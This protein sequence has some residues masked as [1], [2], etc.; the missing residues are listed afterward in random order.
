MN[1]DEPDRKSNRESAVPSGPSNH[2]PA[3]SPRRERS[4][5]PYNPGLHQLVESK[6]AWAEPLDEEAEADGFLGWHQRGYLPHHDVPG[7]TQFLTFRLEDAMPASRRGEWALL[8]QIEDDRRRRTKLEEYLDRGFGKCWLRR[9][10]IAEVVESELRSADGQAYRLCAW[11]IMPNHVH[12]LVEIWETPLAVLSRNW[13]GR[14]AREANKRLNRRGAF[15]ERE[16]WDTRMR[17]EKQLRTAQHYVESNPVK[18][19]LVAEART[20]PWGSAR[21]RDERGNLQPA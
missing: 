20:W 18:A 2:W 1:P 6:Q 12:V 21:F 7:V 15:W 14:S 9:A 19:K 5:P 3:A 8:L 17:D 4:C 11:A 10:A 16:Y 13:K